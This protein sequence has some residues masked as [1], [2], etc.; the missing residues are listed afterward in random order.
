MEIRFCVKTWRSTNWRSAQDDSTFVHTGE[1]E[2]RTTTH[3]E[4]CPF[5]KIPCSNDG[6]CELVARCELSS[7]HDECE[8]VVVPCKYAEIGCKAEVLRRDLKKHMEDQ[9]QHLELL[10]MLYLS[11]MPP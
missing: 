4:E 9:Q 1:Y 3:I 7:H 5:I 6:C 10:L 8:F 2:E 11:F